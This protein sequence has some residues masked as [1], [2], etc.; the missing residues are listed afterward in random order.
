MTVDHD[1]PREHV[2]YRHTGT[3]DTV[4]YVGY[5][6]AGDAYRFS[7]NGGERSLNLPTEDWPAYREHLTVDRY[8]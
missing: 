6:D 5:A 1:T 3:D 7:V 4:T 8:D 2:V